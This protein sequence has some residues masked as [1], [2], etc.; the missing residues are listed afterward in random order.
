MGEI[1]SK[2]HKYGH[3]NESAWP[4]PFGNRKSGR[5][6]YD[7]ERRCIVE[8]SPPPKYEKH[9]QAP[10]A[11]MDSMEKTYHEAAGRHIESRKEWNAADKETGSLTFGSRDEV[12]RH[13]AKG[14]RDKERELKSDRRQAGLSAWQAYRENP[15]EVK[16]KLNKRAEEQMAVA[17]K[18]GLKK[19]LK[20][21]GVTYDN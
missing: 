11:I 20:D 1:K 7:K 5:C 4:P 2:I 10:I 9:G 17:K 14:Q 6:Y 15:K 21:A 13:T 3:E 12:A 18:A 19:H 16:A 8:G